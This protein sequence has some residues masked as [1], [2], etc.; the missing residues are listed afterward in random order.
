MQKIIYFLCLYFV[1][2]SATT[3]KIGIPEFLKD[4]TKIKNTELLISSA[5]SNMDYEVKFYY[6]PSVRVIKNLETGLIDGAFPSNKLR[7]EQLKNVFFIDEPVFEE[8]FFIYSNFGDTVYDIEN[9]ENKIIGV[10]L[11]VITG[12][13]F[14]IKKIKK[15]N[16]YE[17][18]DINSL[19][20]MLISR[21]V[22]YLLLPELQG[23]ELLKKF[24]KANIKKSTL[25][26]NSE[27]FYLLMDKKFLNLKQEIK[28]NIVKE[29]LKLN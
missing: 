14:L 16:F 23:Q 20:N 21:R 8:K 6:L 11:G 25:E 10:N 22:D 26:L 5:F 9:L 4:N 19:G 18:K 1:C 24:P 13:D 15:V 3:I 27:M 2:L 12:R 17:L 29:K 28:N 7:A